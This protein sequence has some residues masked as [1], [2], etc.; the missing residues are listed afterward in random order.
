MQHDES[1]N[2]LGTLD[3]QAARI[4]LLVLRVNVKHPRSLPEYLVLPSRRRLSLAGFIRALVD[5]EK[6]I[7]CDGT[8]EENTLAV[9]CRTLEGKA[10][11]NYRVRGARRS[12]RWE[13]TIRRLCGEQIDDAIL[14]LRSRDEAIRVPF[15]ALRTWYTSYAMR[16]SLS[17]SERVTA[18][19]GTCMVVDVDAPDGT[20]HMTHSDE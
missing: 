1:F 14:M 12:T 7:E 13:S 5:M 16:S 19:A 4:A 11:D 6:P 8:V 20:I 2:D 3:E 15:A 9:Q 17:Y 10:R 18:P